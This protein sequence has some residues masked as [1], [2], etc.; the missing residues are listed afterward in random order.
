MDPLSC[1]P[2]AELPPHLFADK[3]HKP[4]FA[5]K[6]SVGQNQRPEKKA[7]SEPS[8]AAVEYTRRDFY[9]RVEIAVL[10]SFCSLSLPLHQPLSPVIRRP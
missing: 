3:E 4:P 2:G 9:L 8:C 5:F 10:E 6:A 7:L 1:E